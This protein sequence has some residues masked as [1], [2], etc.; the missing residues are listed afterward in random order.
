M[1]D[2]VFE[3]AKKMHWALIPGKSQAQPPIV[4]SL[5]PAVA[6]I[7][8]DQ[9]SRDLAPAVAGTG[10]ESCECGRPSW[11]GPGDDG[12]FYTAD[13]W[14]VFKAS[15]TRP[16]SLGW[17]IEDLLELSVKIRIAVKKYL[18]GETDLDSETECVKGNPE[19]IAQ[20]HPRSRRSRRTLARKA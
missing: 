11:A 1:P 20:Q 16:S 7:K 3:Q 9:Q 14:L 15:V 4:R 2:F 17:D 18:D 8:D 5:A 19:H 13:E 12:N 10:L 6:V